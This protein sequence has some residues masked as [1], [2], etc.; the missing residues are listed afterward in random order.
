MT[1]ASLNS[2]AASVAPADALSVVL[3]FVS[4][5]ES[6]EPPHAERAMAKAR[7]LSVMRFL[8]VSPSSSLSQM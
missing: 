2:P 3:G 4:D 7:E 1:S 8:N 5:V 6:D